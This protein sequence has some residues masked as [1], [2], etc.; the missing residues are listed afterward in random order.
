M[1]G[2]GELTDRYAAATALSWQGIEPDLERPTHA[3]GC[4][5][6]PQ[7]WSLIHRSSPALIYRY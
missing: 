3:K 5:G 1:L 7:S 4:A 6:E 2:K